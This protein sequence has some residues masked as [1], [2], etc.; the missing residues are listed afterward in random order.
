MSVRP[1]TY[2]WVL[3]W[4]G[5]LCIFRFLLSYWAIPRKNLASFL[6]FQ[7][8]FPNFWNFKCQ[9]KMIKTHKKRRWQNDLYVGPKKKNAEGI[10]S[11]SVH[12]NS[13]P[14]SPR[15]KDFSR[16]KRGFCRGNCVVKETGWHDM[17]IGKTGCRKRGGGNFGCH[18]R[19]IRLLWPWNAVALAA[20]CICHD[21]QMR[22]PWPLDAVAMAAECGYH[23][24]WMRLPRLLDAVAIA[25][26][27]GWHGRRMQLPW[28]LNAVAMVAECG[29]HGRWMCLLGYA[30]DLS[31]T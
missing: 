9:K 15:K 4:S 13:K 5:P 26:R 11:N 7:Q 6:T 30:I 20:G 2:I 29:C 12:L 8:M 17:A 18:G 21:H 22:L 24:R 3:G 25:A 14:I 23:G 16:A 27:C 28:P 10:E 19:W 1:S 31:L